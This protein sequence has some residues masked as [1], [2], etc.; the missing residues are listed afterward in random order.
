MREHRSSSEQ[1]RHTHSI[2]DDPTTVASGDR[3]HHPT[4]DV[5]SSALDDVQYMSSSHSSSSHTMEYKNN[6]SILHVPSKPFFPEIHVFK[7]FDVVKESKKKDWRQP[8]RRRS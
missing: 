2:H 6:L 3:S 1:H 8:L 4:T 5:N 7:A